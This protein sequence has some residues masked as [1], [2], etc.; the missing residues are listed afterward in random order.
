MKKIT[1]IFLSLLLIVGCSKKLETASGDDA[2]LPP[3]TQAAD[4]TKENNDTPQQTNADKAKLAAEAEAMK[5]ERENNGVVSENS[6]NNNNSSSNNGNIELQKKMQI[7][8]CFNSCTSTDAT[9]AC[10][11][12]YNNNGGI[13]AQLAASCAQGCGA[14][15]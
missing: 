4:I 13:C 15:Q 2:V 8:Q 7:Q 9:L 11:A 10:L 3:L 5:K 12:Q 1:I 6:T 14:Y